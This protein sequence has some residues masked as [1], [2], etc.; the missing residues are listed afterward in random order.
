MHANASF[1]PQ[2]ESR[3]PASDPVEVV[4]A[5]RRSQHRGSW[6]LWVT[7]KRESKVSATKRQRREDHLA[8]LRIRHDYVEVAACRPD[9]DVVHR[10]RS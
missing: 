7:S 4:D 5:A 8:E 1:S 2:L 9:V 3:T 10:S 6:R